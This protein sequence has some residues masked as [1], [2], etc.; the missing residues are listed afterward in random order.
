[1]EGIQQ[2]HTADK[3]TKSLGTLRYECKTAVKMCGFHTSENTTNPKILLLGERH[4]KKM[5]E[6]HE[7][8]QENQ[9]ELKRS[10]VL[11]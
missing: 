10:V 6:S 11:F 8:K 1:M 9:A 4:L 2:T 7:Q 5:T 3:Q